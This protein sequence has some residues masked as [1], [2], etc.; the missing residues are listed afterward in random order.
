MLVVA[1]LAVTLLAIRFS[2]TGQRIEA[3]FSDRPA[4]VYVAPKKA[5][6]AGARSRAVAQVARDFFY[7]AALRRN[8][9]AA[10]VLA[11][12]SLRQG[13]TRAQWKTGAIPVVPYPAAAFSTA[14]WRLSYS[15]ADR[16]GLEVA[17]RPKPKS[18]IRAVLFTM[19]LHAFGT[20]PRR[21]WLVTSWAPAL[22]LVPP[23]PAEPEGRPSPRRGLSPVWLMAP[24]GVLGLTL[25]IPIV[26]ALREWR[27][28]ARAARGYGSGSSPS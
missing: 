20:G 27:R 19:E 12:P 5:P 1:A 16:V 24:G 6:F 7:Q 26:I 13:L 21:R 8:P 14:A 17:V 11:A 4:Q 9:G 10:W 3:K 23:P 25:L 18:G 2:N 28:G 22:S 15:Y